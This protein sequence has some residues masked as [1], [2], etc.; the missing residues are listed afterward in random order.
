MEKEDLSQI[1][2]APRSSKQTPNGFSSGMLRGIDVSAGSLGYAAG[3][4]SLGQSSP[5]AAISIC[6]NKL[7]ENRATGDAEAGAHSPAVRTLVT[8]ENEWAAA[9]A[10]PVALKQ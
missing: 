7:T 10:G 6:L 2:F 5:P 4:G 8:D 1:L 9:A 3:P